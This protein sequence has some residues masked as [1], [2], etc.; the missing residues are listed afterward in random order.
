MAR[1]SSPRSLRLSRPLGNRPVG[2]SM[3]ASPPPLCHSVLVDQPC[4]QAVPQG[5]VALRG[6]R[7]EAEPPGLREAGP[8]VGPI[9]PARQTYTVRQRG[10]RAERA[11]EVQWVRT[12]LDPLV[13]TAEDCHVVA[14][15][16]GDQHTA[17]GCSGEAAE[18]V[19]DCGQ[20]PPLGV[21]LCGADPMDAFGVPGDLEVHRLD[22]GVY[23]GLLAAG[24]DQDSG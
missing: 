3:S 11:Q 24:E 15:I 9:V 14:E 5:T 20:R 2:P 10:H 17:L 12:G 1:L 4:G 23:D 18:L 7:L 22:E 16:V 8:L 19:E 21:C 6:L 13:L